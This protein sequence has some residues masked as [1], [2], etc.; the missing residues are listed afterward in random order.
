MPGGGRCA[1]EGEGGGEQVHEQRGDAGGAGQQ[2]A[3]D[4]KDGLRQRAEAGRAQSQARRPGG[5]AQ[6]CH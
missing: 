6:A 4:D 3:P 1:E 5:G 2:P